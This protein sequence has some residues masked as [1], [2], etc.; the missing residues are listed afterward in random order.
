MSASEYAERE[1]DAADKKNAGE[2]EADKTSTALHTINMICTLGPSCWSVE[3]LG[4]LIDAGMTVARF[5][6]SHG[7]HPTHAAALARL[8][9]ASALRLVVVP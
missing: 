2:I 4:E 7:D 3:N 6:F 1:L 5:N 8:R 9:E